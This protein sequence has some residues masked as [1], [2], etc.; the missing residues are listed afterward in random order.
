MTVETRRRFECAAC[1]YWYRI[2]KNSTW[3]GDSSVIKR[4]PVGGEI[5]EVCEPCFDDLTRP[6][7]DREVIE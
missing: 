3:A 4:Y 1:G 2:T 7:H 6:L 5:R